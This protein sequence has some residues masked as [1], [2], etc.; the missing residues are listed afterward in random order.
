MGT[1]SADLTA[2]TTVTPMPRPQA[3][4]AAVI[5]TGPITLTGVASTDLANEA[6][7]INQAIGSSDG[8]VATVNAAGTGIDLSTANGTQAQSVQISIRLPRARF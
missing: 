5:S 3:A 4:A 1:G 7:A 2:G 8:I 6:S